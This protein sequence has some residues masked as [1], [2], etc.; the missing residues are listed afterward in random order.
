MRLADDFVRCDT[1]EGLGRRELR[2]LLGRPDGTGA[3]PQIDLSA[4]QYDYYLG[5]E[6]GYISIDSET[7]AVRF[8]S[9]GAV[10]RVLI[11]RD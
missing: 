4:G 11:H 8:G 3:T 9:D 7:L 2:G 5:P 10:R 6:R 1:L